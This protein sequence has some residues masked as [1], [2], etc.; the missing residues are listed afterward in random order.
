MTDGDGREVAG[1]AL[2]SSQLDVRVL[3]FRPAV[4][5]STV[6]ET[7]PQVHAA[8]ADASG[9]VVTMSKDSTRETALPVSEHTH[10]RSGAAVTSSAQAVVN[11]PT[12]VTSS[13]DT[14][15]RTDLPTSVVT[16]GTTLPVTTAGVSQRAAVTLTPAAR[17][18]TAPVGTTGMPFACSMKHP[19]LPQIPNFHGGDQRDRET[20]EDWWDHFE[21]IAGL[22]QNFKLVHLT[23]ALRGNAKS[24]YRSCTTAQKTSYTHLVS[25]LKRDSHQ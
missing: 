17:V 23:A 22:D 10:L 13:M 9:A 4:H 7:T 18:L 25:A 6:E 11:A 8:T 19:N 15:P 3:P 1:T 21:A 12:V 2:S 5:F 16:R 24:F 14:T 20:F